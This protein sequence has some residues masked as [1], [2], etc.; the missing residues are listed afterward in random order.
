M[1]SDYSEDSARETERSES[2][3]AASRKYREAHPDRIRASHAKYDESHAEQKR[4]YRKAHSKEIYA[5]VRAWQAKHPEQVN[6]SKRK[7]ADAHEEESR[8]YRKAHR[9]EALERCARWLDNHREEN[10]VRSRE[11]YREHPEE[12]RA[13]RIA[14]LK[15]HPDAQG[16]YSRNRRARELAAPGSHT[17]ADVRAIWERQQ[18]KCAVPEC[19][20]PISGR[21]DNKF[22]VD[23]IVAL[24]NQG[25]NWP[26][27][28]QILCRQHNIQKTDA[29]DVEW[30]QRTM[31]TLFVL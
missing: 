15:A 4:A 14:W 7:Y 25:S 12:A 11:Y 8:V 13:A 31:G 29:D 16:V 3:R 23:H 22:H 17:E 20:Y 21:G 10:R 5:R 18:H 6:A 2:H 30:A 26:D 1:Q 27:N 9:N 19:T 28:L 24:C